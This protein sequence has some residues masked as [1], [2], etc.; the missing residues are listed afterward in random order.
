MPKQPG[1]PKNQ[2]RDFGELISFE[3]SESGVRWGKEVAPMSK[4]RGLLASLR[5]SWSLSV[6]RILLTE[7]CS[8]PGR[9]AQILRTRSTLL[10]VT[11]PPCPDQL[12]EWDHPFCSVGSYQHACTQDMKLLARENLWIGELD[13]GLASKAWQLGAIWAADKLC[14]EKGT[15]VQFACHAPT[16]SCNSIPP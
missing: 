6:V 13:L 12:R 2:Q 10:G 16:K 8:L 1:S 14:I 3:V 7:V 15:T 5:W 11:I 4:W 9:M